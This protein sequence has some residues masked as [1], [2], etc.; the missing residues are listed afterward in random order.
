MS[1]VGSRA[2]SA[3]YGVAIAATRESL[4]SGARAAS[5]AAWNSGLVAVSVSLE[6]MSVNVAA[7]ARGSSRSMRREARPDSEVSMNPPD[8][9]LPPCDAIA[10]EATSRRTERMSTIQRNR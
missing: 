9:S 3:S 10:A 2:A 4:R 6:K 5:T 7:P 1:F 8:C